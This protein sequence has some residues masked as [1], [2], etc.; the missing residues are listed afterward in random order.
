MQHTYLATFLLV[1][2]VVV[3]ACSRPLNRQSETPTL[4]LIPVASEG[5]S[6]V[7]TRY[8]NR[9]F[10]FSFDYPA[11]YD[12][13]QTRPCTVHDFVR[14]DG[15][16][17]EVYVAHSGLFIYKLPALYLQDYMSLEDHVDRLIK[18]NQPPWRTVSKQDALIDGVKAIRIEFESSDTGRGRWDLLDRGGYRHTFAF[19]SANG[20]CDLPGISE[21][22]VYSHMVAT[23]RFQ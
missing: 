1:I 3:G 5:P 12:A 21:F 18:I 10:G 19:S 9:T 2:A 20:H 4:T 16:G 14:W 15:S 6:G 22:D 17:T 11:G 13:Q 7:W 23:F 8:E